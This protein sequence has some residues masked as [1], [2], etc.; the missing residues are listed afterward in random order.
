MIKVDSFISVS[1]KSSNCKYTFPFS[2]LAQT[3]II[4]HIILNAQPTPQ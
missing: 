3:V 4:L 1:K 2:T